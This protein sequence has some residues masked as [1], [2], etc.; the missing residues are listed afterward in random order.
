MAMMAAIGLSNGL[1]AVEI[2]MIVG[3]ELTKTAPTILNFGANI[4]LFSIPRPG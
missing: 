4:R 2:T 1:P 3:P